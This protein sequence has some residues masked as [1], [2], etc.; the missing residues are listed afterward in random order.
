LY[1][2]LDSSA[3]SSPEEEPDGEGATEAGA[4]ET[5][6]AGGDRRPVWGLHD[7]YIVTPTETGMMLVDQRAAHVRV[8]YEQNQERLRQEQGNSQQ[9]L[10]PHTVELSPADADLLDDLLPDLQAL[11][12]EVEK[13]SG[14]TVAVRGVPADVPDGD[15]KG[16]LEDILEQYK[17]EQDTVEDERRDRLARTMAQKS[18]VRRGEPLSETERRSLLADLFECE[19]PYADPTGTP[20]IAKWSL[21]EIAKRFGR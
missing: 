15:E 16:I 4:T 2:G 1:R 20:T 17:S 21:E 19:M 9:L 5:E 3:Q 10:F 8:L 6:A 18:A 7:T 11:G 13:M 14:R 12:F